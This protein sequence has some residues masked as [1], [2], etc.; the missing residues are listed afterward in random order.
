MRGQINSEDV[1]F[2]L[3]IAFVFLMLAS[4]F[5]AAQEVA[6]SLSSL[7]YLLGMVG[8]FVGQRLLD[9]YDG[10]AA[11]RPAGRA[12]RASRWRGRCGSV[13]CAGAKDEGL[14]FGH[15]V[16]MICLVTG[17]ASLVM[18]A[19]T[20]ETAVRGLDARQRGRGALA[21]RV[22]LAVADRVAARHACRCSWSTGRSRARR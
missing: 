9:G 20:T 15:R 8:L 19:A 3:S 18:Y 6:M 1:V 4:R 16:A 5:M 7:L 12:R 2:Y 10:A 11:H 17:L 22:A 21:R 14:R 13:R